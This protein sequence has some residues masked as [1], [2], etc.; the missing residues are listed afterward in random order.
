MTS[1]TDL[2]SG[3]IIVFFYDIGDDLCFVICVRN[4]V[5]DIRVLFTLVFHIE[6][7]RAQLDVVF[8]ALNLFYS[9]ANY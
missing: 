9:S 4:N 7:L 8:H 2:Y 5:L 3:Q 1:C 6:N